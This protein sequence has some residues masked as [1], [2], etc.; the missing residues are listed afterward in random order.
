[1]PDLVQPRASHDSTI[2]GVGASAGGLEA[3]THLLR[4]VPEGTDLSFVLIQHLDPTHPSTLRETL[5]RSTTMPVQDAEQGMSVEAGHVYVITPNT[6]L[7]LHKGALALS[8]RPT[9][10]KSRHLPIDAFL[11]SLA[12][13]R[14]QRAIGVLLSGQGSDGTEGLRAIGAAAGITF[15]QAPSTAKFT[16]MPQ[17]AIDAG[18]VDTPM[19]I[20]ELAAEL[21][22]LS[23]HPYVSAKVPDIEDRDEGVR[24]D[25]LAQVFAAT[26][27]DF[28]E[29]KPA[30][31]SRRLA[32]RLA[33]RGLTDLR[34]YRTLLDQEPAE[35]HALQEDVL[36][37]VTSFFRD[38]DVYDALRT[39]VLPELLEHK[40]DNGPLR[41]WVA[42]CSSGEE[43]YSLA[44]T[45]LEY[46][47]ATQPTRSLQFFGSDVSEVAIETARA[48]VYNEYAMRA[49]SPERRRNYFV[50]HEHGSYRIQKRVR[51]LCV[52]VV[53]D[54]VR[55]PPFSKLDLV[56]CRNVMIYFGRELQK[57]VLPIFHY[58]LNQPGFL[59]LG[60]SENVIG[61][62]PLFHEVDKVKKV[63]KRSAN[64]SSLRFAPRVQTDPKVSSG[65]GR[66]RGSLFQDYSALIA[67]QLDQLLLTRYSP[68]GVLVKENMEVVLF[69]G[70]TGAYLQAAPGQ[71]QNNLMG[72]AS[73]G[74]SA[75]LRDAITRAKRERTAVHLPDVELDRPDTTRSC[76]LVVIPFIGPPDLVEELFIVLFEERPENLER[77]AR[78]QPVPDA[79][80]SE[81][82]RT[83][84]EHELSATK[85]YQ[86]IMIEEHG[87]AV[88]ELGCANE[89][90]VSANEEL[91]SL[92][93]EL[94]A[95]KEEL[96]SSN[97]ELTTLND[98][99]QRR[100]IEI[101]EV[102]ADLMHFSL[103]VDIAILRI[104]TERRI[105]RFTPKAR[106]IF[107]ISVADIGRVLD[108]VVHNLV[109][110]DLRAKIT[111]V[112]ESRNVI[113]FEV[114]DLAGRWHRIHI[115]PYTTTG[116]QVE[117]AIVSLV[118]IHE[119]KLLV[120]AAE[121]AR[122]EAEQANSIKDDF[123]A[124]LSH[125]LRT[126]L[127]SM[128]LNAQR[129][130]AGDILNQDDLK[131]AGDSLERAVQLQAKLIDDLLDVSRIAAGKLTLECHAFDLS[132]LARVIV[133]G[134]KPVIEAK[135][136]QVKLSLARD[137]GP[138][139]AD[140]TRTQQVIANLLS[141]AIKFTPRLG[142]IEVIVDAADGF[143]RVRI[144]DTGI[145]IS[146]DFLPRAF[147]HFAQS[148]RS[149]TRAYGG[150][151]LG[152]AL[153]RHLVELQ[154]GS[155]HVHS[156]GVDRGA[157]F[158]VTFPFAC[159]DAAETDPANAAAF[160]SLDR[161]GR[162][163][164]YEA[165]AG[166]RVLFID[167]DFRTRE[168]VLEVLELTG[169]RVAL[170]ASV[171]D[172]LMALETFD[173]HVVVCDI[174]MPGEDGYSFMRKL[175]ARELGSDAAIPA[176]ALTALA[177]IDDK[178]RALAAGF[179]LHLAKPIDIVRLRDSVLELVGMRT[180]TQ[181]EETR[182]THAG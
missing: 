32:R 145:G 84:L 123:L 107:N 30:T 164:P 155:V 66:S 90:L 51:D 44:I 52:F 98:E 148:D 182:V 78:E 35:L 158:T 110:P 105:R 19:N 165:L 121:R 167:D 2:V 138:I 94:E 87:R 108:E 153:V 95:A 161:P 38:P 70:Q 124:T 146:P 127:S 47:A 58:C 46:M 85:A 112:I 14:G 3:F 173:P 88:D 122:A 159:A 27:T 42:G 134:M 7:T 100:N 160:H 86:H 149:I 176:L 139:W 175:R 71:P 79:A 17:S 172:G 178:R 129:L 49:V 169:A 24:A 170:A 166:V 150:L 130:R 37:H 62:E 179:Q 23:Q 59:V 91:Q 181:K 109:L 73:G 135:Q 125:E 136:L 9:G 56:S 81:R 99:L 80:A 180:H 117:G 132:E 111:Q 116:E 177:S 77:V 83:R 6:E 106:T 163:K 13:E 140:A 120:G 152:L 18:V 93:E 67:R 143:A 168:A 61:F 16:S 8:P 26:G 144:A 137:L 157:T 74:L 28:S 101:A 147:T 39:Q 22:R 114:E 151:G 41:I 97:E 75:A 54:L 118:D 96:Q 10:A 1:M 43:V 48:G 15:A 162:M 154:G 53:H 131:R 20:P 156:A 50:A 65:T 25:I 92:N 34:S 82:R 36:I 40:S 68:P 76:D 29:F 64:V 128:L 5:T 104:D 133:E 57:R 21:H 4:L 12:A 141:N 174:A 72:M 115:R 103:A 11:C 33:L 142:Q 69:R 55:D 171:A 102:S 119:L 113:D 31:V 126:P 45:L 63:W 60:R 89:E